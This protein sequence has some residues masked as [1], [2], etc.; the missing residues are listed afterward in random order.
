MTVESLLMKTLTWTIDG[1]AFVLFRVA[2]R[3]LTSP[4]TK[5]K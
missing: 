5:V 1:Q 2:E 4:M 3:I